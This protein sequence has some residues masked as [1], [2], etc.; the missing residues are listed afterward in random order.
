MPAAKPPEFRRRAVDLA[1]AGDQS[2]AKI[3]SDLGIS[4]SC[5]R[6]WMAVDDVDAGRREGLT[7]SERKELVELRPAEPCAGDGDRDPQTRVG[8]L[9][10]RERPPKRLTPL[11]REL[12]ADRVPVAVTCRVLGISRSG[13]YDAA[14]R[15]P[16]PRAVS[17]AALTAT[18]E[19]VHEMSRCSYGAPRVHAELRLGQGVRVGRKRVARLMRLAGLSGISHRRK[20]G[21]SRP[22]PAPHEDLVRRQFVADSPDRLWATD[23]TEHPTGTGKVYCCAVIDAYSRMVVGWSIAD[24]IR[25]DLVVDALQMATWRRQPQPGTTACGPPDCSAPWA[26]SPPAST[27]P[28]SR[29]SGRPCNANCS[30]PAAGPVPSSC[31]PRSSSGSRPGT[32]PAAGTPAPAAPPPPPSSKPFTDPPLPRHDQPTRSVR[33]TGSGSLLSMIA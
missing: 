23:V 28:W 9:R 18:I 26:V 4:E 8:L 29:A 1:R 25:T 11:V 6:R 16:S 10:P 3:A 14:S 15:P 31:P 17:D 19:Q 20:R 13:F 5:L 12:A 32:T 33:R 27:T 22:L 24:H 2:V 21:R 7:T 30:T